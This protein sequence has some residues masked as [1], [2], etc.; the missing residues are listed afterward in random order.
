MAWKWEITD[1]RESTNETEAVVAVTY[2]DGATT[3]LSWVVVPLGATRAELRQAV[4]A[5]GQAVSARAALLNDLK[6]EVGK[7]G[8]V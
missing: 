4:K 6:A 5:Q 3:I 7:D 2:T 8:N 1:V